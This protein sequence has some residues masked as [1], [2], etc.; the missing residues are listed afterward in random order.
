MVD[1]DL[2]VES[3][4]LYMT[5]LPSGESFVWR[6]L[7]LKEYRTFAALRAGAV[8]SAME[9][10][11]KVFDRC[12]VGDPRVING[13]LPAGIF[14]AIGELILHLSGD[15]AGDEAAEIDSAREQYAVASVQEVMK[16]VVLMAFPYKPEEL[17]DWTRPRL[18]RTFVQAEAVLANKS[19]YEP[20]DTSKI[21]TPEQIAKQQNKPVV[22]M[23]RENRE[24][25]DEFGDRTHALDRDPAELA[26][27]AKRQQKLKA[28]QLRKL[29][30]SKRDE[31]RQKQSR[32][33]R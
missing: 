25:G 24:I 10:H 13:N 14:L 17:D 9:L 23:R 28:D 1:I 29:D 26:Q 16:R 19:G 15:M 21:M 20:L 18:T 31:A 22:D 12:Y 2:L 7:S 11:T 4:G 5:S 27:R 6:L 3:D 33:R 30:A 8:L 32:R